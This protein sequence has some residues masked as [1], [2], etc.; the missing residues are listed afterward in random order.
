MTMTRTKRARFLFVTA[1]LLPLGWTLTMPPSAYACS[2]GS[3]GSYA[4]Y[5]LDMAVR[6]PHLLVGTVSSE[7]SMPRPPNTSPMWESVVTVD[8]VLKGDDPG[9]PLVIP[10]IGFLGADCS[11]GPRLRQGERVLLAV[12][13]GKPS[14]GD[15]AEHWQISGGFGKVLIEDGGA[16]LEWTAGTEALGPADDVVREYGMRAG[17]TNDQIDAAIAAVNAPIVPVT[18]GAG[19]G[20]TA[21]APEKGLNGP[22][23]PRT[24][25]ALAVAAVALGAFVVIRYRR[26]ANGSPP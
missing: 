10:Y 8:A 1:L 6:T 15:G 13:R 22:V 11:G 25:L 9:A 14:Y 26:S 7:R 3:T 12:F 20:S 18:A 2:I 4:R 16:T 19:G 21:A 24:G 17:A 5:G 23:W